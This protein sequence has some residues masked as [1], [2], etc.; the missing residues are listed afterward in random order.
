METG[1]PA[2]IALQPGISALTV[3]RGSVLRRDAQPGRCFGLETSLLTVVEENVTCAC[4]P[5]SVIEARALSF[6]P[7]RPPFH[8]PK[9]SCVVGFPSS[10]YLMWSEAVGGCLCHQSAVSTFFARVPP[11]QSH[12]L[13]QG[14]PGE[15]CKPP[16]VVSALRCV[17]WVRAA[18]PKGSWSPGTSWSHALPA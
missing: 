14:S 3:Q 10:P 11:I 8:L 7:K 15:L 6:L 5:G 4:N 9:R 17:Y 18:F 16:K 1:P 12:G 13:V 2:G